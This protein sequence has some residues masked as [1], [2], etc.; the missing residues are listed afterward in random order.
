MPN[1]FTDNSATG[2]V[3]DLT[4]LYQGPD[5]PRLDQDLSAANEKALQFVARYKG[6][7]RGGTLD[8]NELFSAIQEYES[9]HESGMRPRVF[10]YLYNASHTQDHQG[11]RL[12]QK[13]TE[14][15]GEISRMLTFFRV[16]VSALSVRSLKKLA[17]HPRLKDYR[18]FLLRQVPFKPHVLS[19]A[20]EA[21]LEMKRVSSRTA[22][23]SL[24]DDLMAGLC[25][26]VVIRGK[27][28]TLD[29]AG[30]LALLYLPDRSLREKAFHAFL[31]ELAGY[32]KVFNHILN[33]LLLDRHLEDK[34]RGHPYPM[35]RRHLMNG[36]D[37][38]MVEGMMNAVE[39][40]YPTARRYFRLKARLMGLERLKT[41]DLLA[42][43]SPNTPRVEFARAVQLLMEALEGDHP[44][45][46]AI[47]RSAFEE[48]WIDAEPRPGKQA[49]AFCKSLVPS[50]HPYI[51]INYAGTLNDLMTLAH[52]LGHF[53]HYR[54]ASQQSYLNFD[55]PPVLAEAAS[56]FMEFMITDH[57]MKKQE[58]RPHVPNLLASRMEGI[59]TTI[60]RQTVITRFEQAIH[61]LRKDHLLSEEEICR[62]WWEENERLYKEDV[63]MPPAYQWG[64]AYVHHLIHR[65]FYC[66]S[67]IFGNLLSTILFQNYLERGRSFLDK[68]IRLFSAGASKA[69]LEIL[70]EVDLD[71]RPASFWEP[72]FQYGG[73]LIDALEMSEKD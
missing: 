17:A 67:Y 30:V 7:L 71:P 37:G 20:E 68:I 31:D 36:M 66:Y 49:G 73:R 59:L 47:A 38:D 24:Y 43:L 64:W 35:H 33:A 12:F 21:I 23:V 50:L 16:D 54:L 42:P 70:E 46:H 8:A 6:R 44:R 32:G 15:W 65:P 63:E 18:N 25:I 4:D 55:P 22:F 26:E 1:P 9:I 10:A 28:T 53:I 11:K 13:V 48:K 2:I 69:P 45:L 41:T 29:T 14:T 40:H 27:A 72:A 57:L 5:D 62:L 19:E 56:T 52:E 3:W 58:F 51:S 39:R 61:T 34:K 60:F